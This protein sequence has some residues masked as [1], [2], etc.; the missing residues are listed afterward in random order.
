MANFDFNIF[1]NTLNDK[2]RTAVLSCRTEAEFEQV[3]DDYDI[4]IPDD[5]LEMVSGG[6]SGF[7]AVAMATILAVTGA[8]A[9]I[10]STGG[11]TADAAVKY[12][13]L[14][15]QNNTKLNNYLKSIAPRDKG[16]LLVQQGESSKFDLSNTA[17]NEGS[18]FVIVTRKLE[19]LENSNPDLAT[20]EGTVDGVYPGAVVHADSKLVDGCPNILPIE[21]KN[22]QPL[23]IYLDIAGN[24]VPT[25]TVEDVSYGNVNPV[26]NNMLEDWFKGKREAAAKVT[27]KCI[28]VHS[29][30]QVDMALGVK[31][32]ADKYGVDAKACMKGE[33]QQ[34]LVVFNQVYYN[35][36]TPKTTAAGL[37]VNDVDENDLINAGVDKSN[38]G[39]AEVTNMT[40]GRQIIVKLETNSK[41]TE[42][43]TA[44]RA[45]VSATKI[46]ASAKYMDIMNSTSYSVCA[47]GGNAST[48]GRLMKN[49]SISD[50]NDALTADLRFNASTPAVPLGYSTTFIDDATNA[51][52]QRT[53]QYVTTTR[54]VRK[55]ISYEVDSASAW[56]EKTQRL[57]GKRII[58]VDSNGNPKLSG[59]EEISTDKGDVKKYNI[60]GAYAEFGFE[61]DVKLGTDWPYS[62]VFWR[63]NDGVVSGI[64]IDT[65]GPCRNVNVKIEVK[66]AESDSYSTVFEKKNCDSHHR[67]NW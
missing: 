7:A 8:G 3:I 39:L 10:A 33:K 35:V 28:M 62:D 9:T 52:V 44:W 51:T 1:L 18:D 4:E 45:S 14:A 47:Y 22:R 65:G 24:T 50:I 61:V 5:M 6:K 31:G 27:Y 54:Q 59:W 30:K 29:E 43:E 34:M 11:M 21:G 16:S 23:Q 66:K 15:D 37:F 56:K 32:A 40:Y 46:E 57:M 64:K 38:P 58:G 20:L 48:V 42:V 67:Y 12:G 19:S 36:K 13:T 2:Q 53:T 63:I 49:S 17:G 25:K 41:S 26:I 60:S 55:P